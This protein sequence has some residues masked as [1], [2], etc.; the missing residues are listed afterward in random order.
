MM[1]VLQPPQSTHFSQTFDFDHDET[2]YNMTNYANYNVPINIM[3]PPSTLYINISNIPQLDGNISLN[4]SSI[5]TTPSHDMKSDSTKLSEIDLNENS[6][7]TASESN[8]DS[9]INCNFNEYRSNDIMDPTNFIP[10]ISSNRAPIPTTS[11]PRVLRIIK[12]NAQER[13]AEK[14][15][16]ISVINARSLWPK[17]QSFATQFRETDTDIAILTEVWGKGSKKQIHQITELLEMK[18][19][20]FA[21]DIRKDRRGGGTAVAACAEK[22]SL[23]RINLPKEK[24]LELT[25]VLIENKLKDSLSIPII[26][27]SVYSSSRSKYKSQLIDFLTLQI[28]RLKNSH[29]STLT[30]SNL[31]LLLKTHLKN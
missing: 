9:N 12:A 8:H 5:D 15:P 21:F 14:L 18:G 4:D 27:F 24:G 29:P 22:F 3:N 17:L 25:A 10:V 1:G 11:R 23:T 19:I 31:V 6:F 16:T 26:V 13:I 20:D 28:S 2:K 7:S 30:I